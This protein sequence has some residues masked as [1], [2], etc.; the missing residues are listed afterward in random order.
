MRYLTMRPSSRMGMIILARSRRLSV[1]IETFQ[2]VARS[3]L[4][5]NVLYCVIVR[6][7]YARS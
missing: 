6:A 2:R 5:S 1:S 7:A 3:F 4:V